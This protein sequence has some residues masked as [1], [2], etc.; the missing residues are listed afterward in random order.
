MT[1]KEIVCPDN[2]GPYPPEIQTTDIFTNLGYR[3]KGWVDPVLLPLRYPA[4]VEINDDEEVRVETRGDG[5]YS[6]FVEKIK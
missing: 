5:G 1:K 4:I 3:Q 6:I 2:S